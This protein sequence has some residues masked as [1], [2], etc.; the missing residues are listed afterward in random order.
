MGF[1]AATSEM[2]NEYRTRQ[3]VNASEY[4]HVMTSAMWGSIARIK[5]SH[6][7]AEGLRAARDGSRK[8]GRR[9]NAKYQLARLHLIRKAIP[10]HGGK[11]VC[12]QILTAKGCS[13][14]ANTYAKEGFCHFVPKSQIYRR[15]P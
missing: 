4:A 2:L 6:N 5:S 10:P 8:R 15:T 14:G 13:G 12:F 3:H 11:K 7:S 9:E 1:E